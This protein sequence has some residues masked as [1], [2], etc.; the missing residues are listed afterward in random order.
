MVMKSLV[1]SSQTPVLFLPSAMTV[2][3][4]GYLIFQDLHFPIYKIGEEL[5]RYCSKSRGDYIEL[6]FRAWAPKSDLVMNLNPSSI[7]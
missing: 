3:Y 1:L 2:T 4:L 7:T 5:D 6:G